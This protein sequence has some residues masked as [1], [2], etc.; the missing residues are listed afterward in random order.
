VEG[1]EP[2]NYKIT[3]GDPVVRG[4]LRKHILYS[5]KVNISFLNKITSKR[6]L[7]MRG[8]STQQE[9]TA[10]LIKLDSSCLNCGQDVIFHQY[11]RRKLL[12][13]CRIV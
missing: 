5:I 3:C 7:V 8:K 13:T 2:L 12:E 4:G 10:T 9:D 11:H 1:L 6:E